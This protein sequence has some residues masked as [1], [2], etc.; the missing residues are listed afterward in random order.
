MLRPEQEHEFF[1]YTTGRFLWNERARLIERHHTFNVAEL[2]LRVS[3]ACGKER[4]HITS[5]DKS[6]EGGWHR[7]FTVAFKDGTEVIA[8]LPYPCN[9]PKRYSTLSEVATMA[10][11]DQHGIPVP[12]VY[13]WSATADNSVGSEYIIMEKVQGT[14]LHKTWYS[15]TVGERLQIVERIVRLERVLFDISLPAYGSIYFKDSLSP[16]TPTVDIP[17]H[18]NSDGSP[19]FCIGPSTELL[20]WY[21]HRDKL[22]ANSGPWFD[23]A[24]VLEAVG[25]RELLWLEKFGRPRYPQESI[26]RPVYDYQKVEP[27]VQRKSLE[28]YLKIARFLVPDN[29][30][31]NRPTIRHPDLSPSNIFIS[32]RGEI[33]GMIDWQHCVVLPLFLQAKIPSHFENYGD[34]DSEMH[35]QP[36]LP[37]NFN[38]LPD[39]DKAIQEE[40][41]RK[42][43][44]HFFYLGATSHM[45]R[46][47]YS[48]LRSNQF[49]YV[50]RLYN[51]AR[52]PWE[53]DNTTLK[54]HLIPIITT[55][56]KVCRKDAPD[57]PVHYSEEEIK[58]CLRRHEKQLEIDQGMQGMRNFVGVNPE[59]WVDNDEYEEAK[60]KAADIKAQW[61]AEAE[62]EFERK[63]IEEN[64]PLQDHEEID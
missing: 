53:G 15:M 26:Y 4:H 41:Y 50:S 51:A 3:K 28:D 23:S 52:N 11:L 1:N 31:M 29:E 62:S 39:E 18:A 35:R 34:E 37:D 61:I 27:E 7:I 25:K 30:E 24:E 32:T 9:L 45:N 20:W 12:K 17:S 56:P 13:D 59:G 40:I 44:L 38:S 47:H 16:G 6:A 49:T 57:C 55:W 54:A 64:F 21:S 42:R 22:G 33:A 2:C 19:R 58:E 10:F 46:L 63:D 48:A 14:D 60:K 5:V 8:R 36:K 43:Q